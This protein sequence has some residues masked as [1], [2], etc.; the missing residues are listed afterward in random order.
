MEMTQEQLQEA[1]DRVPP[2]TMMD[3]VLRR[4]DSE[5]EIAT[6]LFVHGERH[7]CSSQLL[8]AELDALI[9][10]RKRAFLASVAT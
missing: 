2:R 5:I 4:L 7:G 10:R 3:T 6:I 9:D 8:K 1:L